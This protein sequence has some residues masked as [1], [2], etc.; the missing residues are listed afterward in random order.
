MKINII[1]TRD[2]G[3]YKHSIDIP[4]GWGQ[5]TFKQYLGLIKAG[6]DINETLSVFTGIDASIIKKAI[7]KNLGA[8]TACLHFLNK[9][10]VYL[11]PVT[12]MGFKIP[13]NLD[14]E[15]T[16]QFEDLK[17]ILS[18]MRYTSEEKPNL[19]PEDIQH[20]YSLYPLIVATF[21]ERPYDY[22]R[23][24][25]LA[26]QFLNAPCTEVLAIGNFTRVRLHALSNGMLPTSRPD[27]GTTLHKLKLALINWLNNLASSIR[28][29]TWKR[30]LPSNEQRFLNGL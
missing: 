17:D 16:A 20:N 15:S 12:C 8:V 9:P 5:V 29:H 18:K 26:K 24:E 21:A 7:V 11:T 4:T 28:Y 14:G 10:P 3:P 1:T 23:A 25:Y 22:Q 30:S 13:K 19:T 2:S 27:R 6:S